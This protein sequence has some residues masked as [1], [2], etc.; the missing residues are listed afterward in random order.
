MTLLD[1]EALVQ[2]EAQC[3]TPETVADMG[4]YERLWAVLAVMGGSVGYG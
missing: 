3:Q 2:E 4:G 1:L